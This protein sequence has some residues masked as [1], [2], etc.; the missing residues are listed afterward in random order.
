MERNKITIGFRLTDTL[1][2][3]FENTSEVVLFED[4][5]INSLDAIGEQLNAFLSQ[6]GFG[7][8]RDR[9]LMNGLT[10]EEY[11]TLLMK[12]EEMRGEAIV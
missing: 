3:T 2:Q 9:I 1:G 4:F 7:G 8:R 11:D 10:D 5:G 12:L 6:C